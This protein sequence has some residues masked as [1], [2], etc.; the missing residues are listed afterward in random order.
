MHF[1]E[2]VRFRKWAEDMKR[3]RGRLSSGGPK[4][5]MSLRKGWERDARYVL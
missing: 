5:G 1:V 4:R 2:T 3:A